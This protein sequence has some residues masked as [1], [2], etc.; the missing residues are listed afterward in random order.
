MGSVPSVQKWT[1]KKDFKPGSVVVV[2]GASSGLGWNLSLKYAE[3]QCPV[4][5]SGR[6]E[7]NKLV[8]LTE[9]CATS[10]GNKQVKYKVAEATSEEDCKEV[11]R[12]ALE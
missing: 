9:L 1:H 6:N 4:V 12:F 8:E 5:V 11:V 7:N 2:F 3:R 10:Y